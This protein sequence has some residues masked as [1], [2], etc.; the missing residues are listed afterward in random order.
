[1]TDMLPRVKLCYAKAG[2]LVGLPYVFSGG[3]NS[4]WLPSLSFAQGIGT[5]GAGVDCSS[6]VS[7]VLRAGGMCWNPRPPFPLSTGNLMEWGE[8][9]LGLYMSVYVRNDAV[10]EHTGLW[11]NP[12]FFEHEWWQAP[13]TG[14]DVGWM[15]L[16]T[17]GMIVRHWPNS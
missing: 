4:L 5:K 16:D 15:T 11:F 2:S 6:G 3:H 1:M 10:E 14:A 9:G 17:T 8:E 7:I 12:R 13:H